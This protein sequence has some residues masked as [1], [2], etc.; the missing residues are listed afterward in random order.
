MSKQRSLNWWF[1]Y[2]YL[3]DCGC[4]RDYYFE[5]MRAAYHFCQNFCTQ[6]PA[7]KAAVSSL[8]VSCVPTVNYCLSIFVG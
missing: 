8:P 6:G 3:L 5:R 2:T 1:R 4:P 7:N